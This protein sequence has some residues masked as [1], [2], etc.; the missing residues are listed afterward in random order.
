MKYNKNEKYIIFDESGNL[1]QSGRYFVISCIETDYYKSVYNLM[2]KK[3][4]QAKKVFPELSIHNNEIKAK[5][6][7]PMVK[8]HILE[9]LTSKNIKIHYIVADL[10]HIDKK[11]L[12]E[13]NIF[14]N[15]L[16][17][18]LLDKIIDSN[19]SKV[20]IIFDNHSTKVSSKNSLFEYLKIH[21]IYDKNFNIDFNLQFCD[22]DSNNG[23]CIQAIDYIANAIYSKYEYTYFEFYNIIEDKVIN[24]MEFPYNDF[25]K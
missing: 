5:D 1:G 16:I 23:Y 4:N 21:F 10:L 9:C 18:L 17:R 3:I 20:N 14:Y 2:H 12:D 24:K 22:S 6:A 7:Y 8:Y 13:K 19:S 25:G 11:L 15:Y